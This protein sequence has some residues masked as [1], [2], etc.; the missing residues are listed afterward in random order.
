MFSSCSVLYTAHSSLFF[1]LRWVNVL[2]DT[3]EGSKV[4]F[5][6]V[7]GDAVIMIGEAWQQMVEKTGH[8]LLT[9]RKQ[10]MTRKW[11]QA[12]KPQG[13]PLV[14]HFLQQGSTLP[15]G[16]ISWVPSV[17][18]HGQ[19]GH[20]TFKPQQT[21]VVHFLHCFAM[22]CL[23]VCLAGSPTPWSPYFI[24]VFPALIQHLGLHRP[25]QEPPTSS[26]DF[27][28]CF[29]FISVTVIKDFDPKQI[30]EE[31]VPVQHW[32]KAGLERKAGAWRRNHGRMLLAGSI[33][34]SRSASFFIAQDY[35]LRDSAAHSGLDSPSSINNQD[36][37]CKTC[38][39]ANLLEAIPPPRCIVLT[40]KT[41]WGQ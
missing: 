15:K 38:S 11:C 37:L 41:W 40:I 8:M 12:I 6:L 36:C 34:G 31:W 20:F 13:P 19:G 16:T 30:G 22:E 21:L 25:L 33:F 17:Q 24:T 32:W 27:C 39:Q 23:S 7:R 35:C 1:S 5:G 26:V 10:G 28:V 2:Q 4:S 18:I 14:I 3:T 29:S 9:V